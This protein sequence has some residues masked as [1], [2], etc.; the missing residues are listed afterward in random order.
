MGFPASYSELLL[1]PKILLHI[2]LIL[3]CL[4]RF[5]FRLFDA[6]GLGDLVDSD[7]PW[8]E[9]SGR[10]QLDHHHHHH[11]HHHHQQPAQFR[12]VSAMLIQE[13]LPVVRYKE[14]VAAGQHVGGSCAVCLC[15][16]EDAEEV[17][18]LNNCRHVFHRGC[19][20]RWLEFDQRT[21]PLC[22]TPLVGEETQDV[23]D[24]QM[25]AA[26]GVP[27]SYY[28]DYY[29]FPFVSPSPSSPSSLLLA[30]QL[31]SSY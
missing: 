31:F 17:R 30:H 15:E 19:I 25:W 22:R 11:H 18:R 21:C 10:S 5:V 2:A 23:L 9:N 13:A 14:L 7:A 1:L 29:S 20:D 26:A 28:D 27:D 16:F 24:D 4:R 12:S 8:P 3:G 6:V